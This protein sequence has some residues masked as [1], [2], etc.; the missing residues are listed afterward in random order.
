MRGIDNNTGFMK[1]LETVS[2]GLMVATGIT[3]TRVA[4]TKII[5]DFREQ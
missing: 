1:F 3:S 5:R 2:S 4:L